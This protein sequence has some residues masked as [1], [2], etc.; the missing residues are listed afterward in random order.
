MKRKGM[1]KFLKLGIHCVCAVVLIVAVIVTNVILKPMEEQI[2][3]FLSQPIVDEEA[4]AV[5]SASGQKLSERIVEEGA[6]MFKNEND[7]LPLDYSKDKKVNVFGW[8]SVDWIHGSVGPN[9]SGG[10]APETG[11]Y[12]TNIGLLKALKNYG[13]SYNARLQA[14]YESYHEPDNALPGFGNPHISN[15]VPLVEPDINNKSYYSDELLEYSK[16]FSDVAIVVIGR[17]AGEGMN[18]S[19]SSQS[20]R[21]DG[22]TDDSTRH[23]LEISTE[24][25]N[26]L[27]YVGANYE[28]VIVLLS[29]ANQFEC[30]FL[31]TIPGIDSCLYIGFTGTR[32]VN[33]L[34]KVLYGEVSPSGHAVDTFAYDLWTNPANVYG[35]ASYLDYGRGYTD[36]VE[37]IYVGYKWYETADAE[38][39]WKDYKNEKDAPGKTGYEAVVQFPFGYGLSYNTYSWEVAEISVAPESEITDST[40]INIT[41]NVT[42]NGNVPGREVIQAYVTPPYT[43]GG[44]EKSSVALCSI[45]KTEIIQPGTTVPVSITVDAYDFLSYDC[46][47]KNGD[48]HKGYE[49]EAGSYELKLM[50]DAHN[51]KKVT[52]NSAEQDGAFKYNV[53]KT[54]N[55][56]KDPVT[57][58]TVKNLF[59]G[60]DA[61][62]ASPI[63]AGEKDG[64]YPVEIGWFSRAGKD[65]KCAFPAQ[66]GWKQERRNANPA[67]KR[68]PASSVG[69]VWTDWANA[70]TDE[71]GNEV[72]TEKPTWGVN[73]GLKVTTEKKINELG[74]KLGAD[75]NA[76]EWEDLLNQLSMTEV[77]TLFNGYYGSKAISSVGKPGLA[78]YDGPAQ[79]KGFTSA[80]RGTGYPTMTVVAATFNPNLAYEFGQSY[81]KDMISVG[82]YGIWGWAMDTHRTAWFGRNHE[83]PSEDGVLAGII[84]S[85]AVKGLSTTGR[86]CFIKHFALYG[87]GNQHRFLTEQNL[88]ENYLRGFRMAFVDGEALGCMTTYQGVGAENS[89]TTRALL[90]GVLRNEWQFKGAVT[91]DAHGTNQYADG[92]FYSGG[93]FGMG[94]SLGKATY[95]GIGALKYDS[96]SSARVQNRLRESAKQ[97]LYM[98]LHADY[99]ADGYN[100]YAKLLSDM[101][102][103]T[104]DKE[105]YIAQNPEKWAEYQKKYPVSSA[106]SVS[107]TSSINTWEWY[108]V[109]LKVASVTVYILC[110]MWIALAL[111]G[112]FA[113]GKQKPEIEGENGGNE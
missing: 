106:N 35:G 67:S 39:F 49:L 7:A 76:P 91:T 59:T 6:V 23:Y 50:T 60:A 57:N 89:E 90:V 1:N 95:E 103:G 104:V 22:N 98:W 70:T 27:K 85:N 9:A 94:N 74:K 75:Y 25:E 66:E 79:I 30:G 32:G 51:V 82:V 48:G 4:L 87:S 73:K 40:K 100:E 5:S 77:V 86:Y 58:Q 14:M 64:T 10:V 37:N 47:D 68:D 19:S 52:Y 21:G 11:D 33:A 111:I 61:V 34:P 28:K 26:L 55:V 24:E 20:K 108:P 72:S 42:N 12:S 109:F 113:K 29:V 102:K 31:N 84:I 43:P 71:F 97:V 8:R 46:Y 3:S 88:R 69:R 105:R 107:S 38:G 44:I 78:D 101:E 56:D 81:G 110:G 93:N 15:F 18:A 112:C 41:I 54:I 16:S 17:M 96:A 63:D 36:Y 92:L 45:A 13:I 99:C 65:G 2:S 53:A 80:P 83:S 62:D